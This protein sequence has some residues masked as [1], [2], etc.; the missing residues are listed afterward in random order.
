[1]IKVIIKNNVANILDDAESTPGQSRQYDI[2]E[3]QVLPYLNTNDWYEEFNK[4]KTDFQ[5]DK[6]ID[7]ETD[8]LAIFKFKGE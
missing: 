3:N 5:L 6:I 7:R 8:V 2:F 1:M 4:L